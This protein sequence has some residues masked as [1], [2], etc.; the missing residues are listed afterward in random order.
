MNI[1]VYWQ[2]SYQTF[3]YFVLLV[4][5]DLSITPVRLIRSQERDIGFNLDA[6]SPI[7]TQ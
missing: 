7:A 5:S 6:N 2:S 1:W 4:M 3:F